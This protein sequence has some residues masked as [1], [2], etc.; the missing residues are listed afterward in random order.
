MTLI[1][2]RPNSSRKSI[3]VGALG[4]SV[5]DISLFTT[6]IRVTSLFI[7]SREKVT[8]EVSQVYHETFQTQDSLY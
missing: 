7:F 5:S 6:T 1:Y 2:D 8:K 3:L 4:L